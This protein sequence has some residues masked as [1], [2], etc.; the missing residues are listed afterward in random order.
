[1]L[2]PSLLLLI[3]ACLTLSDL[4]DRDEEDDDV[5]DGIGRGGF[6]LELQ[7]SVYA[8]FSL[9]APPFFLSVSLSDSSRG[10]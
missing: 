9:S 6:C 8:K 10:D 1:L 3:R 2:A 7:L 4:P 5:G